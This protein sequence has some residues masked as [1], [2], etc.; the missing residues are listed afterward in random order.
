M[1][2]RQAKKIYWAYYTGKSEQPTHRWNTF[3]KA[4]NLYVKDVT[5]NYNRRKQ[6]D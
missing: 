6:N 2:I 4:Q 3:I 1:K 5:K